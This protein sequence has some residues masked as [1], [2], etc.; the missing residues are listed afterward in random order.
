[1]ILV[2]NVRL[3]F[4][5]L[6]TATSFQNE[7]P[8]F[9]AVFLL[10]KGSEQEKQ[11]KA[12]IQRVATE[13]FGDQAKMIV[14][15]QNTTNRKLLKDGDGAEGFTANG[16]QKNGYAG[17]SYIKGTSKTAP[18]VV[19][20]SRQPLTE[21]DGIP[22][23]GCIVN[24]QLD[25][26]AQKNQFGKAVNCKL[27]AVQFWDEGERLGGSSGADVDAFDVAEDDNWE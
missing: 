22:Y 17:H 20:R 18:K 14:D 1:M 7:E 4:P 6:F 24:V 23:A 3:S 10:P 19:G 25:I 26:W 15:R 12:E 11:I 27:L 16:E 9:S 2:K 21:A 8:K 13:A 5:S